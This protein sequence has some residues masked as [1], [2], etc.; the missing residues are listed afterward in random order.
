MTVDDRAFTQAEITMLAIYR[1]RIAEGWIPTGPIA[2]EVQI[3]MLRDWFNKR[4]KR[5]PAV[6]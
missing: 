1:Q 4:F 5:I 2:D 3:L 6:A